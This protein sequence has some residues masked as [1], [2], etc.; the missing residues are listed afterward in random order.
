M[1]KSTSRGLHREMLH[2]VVERIGWNLR[3]KER[4]KIRSH[5]TGGV[6]AIIDESHWESVKRV[7]DRAL[8]N[9]SIQEEGKERRASKGN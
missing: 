1:T 7:E 8:E 4:P 9:I 5:C 3:W 2:Q 6:K